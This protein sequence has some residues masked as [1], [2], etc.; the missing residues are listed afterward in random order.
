M[1]V[2]SSGIAV[3]LAVATQSA[4]ATESKVLETA[5]VKGGS[6][7]LV[8]ERCDSNGCNMVAKFV[9]TKGVASTVELPWDA[10]DSMFTIEPTGGSWGAVDSLAPANVDVAWTS[11]DEDRYLGTAM[12]L[13]KLP[14]NTVGIIVDQRGGFDTIVH[15]HVLMTVQGTKLVEAKRWV[16]V[17]GPFWSAVSV[18]NGEVL[19]H[20]VM[21]AS[22]RGKPDQSTVTSYKWDPKRLTLTQQKRQ[23][24]ISVLVL[25]TYPSTTIAQQT[26][27]SSTDTRLDGTTCLQGIGVFASAPL[28][29]LKGKAFLGAISTSAKYATDRASEIKVCTKRWKDL[30][31]ATVN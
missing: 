31:V 19:H 9:S 24:P 30:T 16:S 1:V 3:N 6:I 29:G 22:E 18:V 8:A 28:A 21:F 11:G 5:P 27:D 13:V 2:V 20:E 14:G 7:Q 12:R 23:A 17:G 25:A 15:A 10:S 26:L 4:P